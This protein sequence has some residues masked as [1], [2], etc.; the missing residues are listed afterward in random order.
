MRS[1]QV[2]TYQGSNIY[3]KENEEQD[4]P[5]DMFEKS[6]LSIIKFQRIKEIDEKLM[7]EIK[8][9]GLT[10]YDKFKGFTVKLAE[11]EEKIAN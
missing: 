5:K 8:D 1:W 11:E 3:N 6:L 2:L 10:G 4:A 9:D 7:Q